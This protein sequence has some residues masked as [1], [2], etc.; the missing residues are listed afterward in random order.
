M[1]H[2]ADRGRQIGLFD[3]HS[4][5]WTAALPPRWS[6]GSCPLVSV[7]DLPE[8]SLVASLRYGTAQTLMSL[9]EPC[10]VA[11]DTD[12]DTLMGQQAV[13]IAPTQLSVRMFGLKSI[14]ADTTR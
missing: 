8:L 11:L 2:L 13:P 9:K 5:S 4:C 12:K 1:V 14:A 6:S 10:V 7:F 3:S